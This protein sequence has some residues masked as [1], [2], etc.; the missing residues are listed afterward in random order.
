MELRRPRNKDITLVGPFDGEKNQLK[1]VYFQ[2]KNVKVRNTPFNDYY[3]RGLLDQNKSNTQSPKLKYSS[4]EIKK[5]EIKVFDTPKFLK[6][7]PKKRVI[8]NPIFGYRV[9]E[10]YYIQKVVVRPKSC[11]PKINFFQP[12][13]PEILRIPKRPKI[14][15]KMSRYNKRVLYKNTG[16]P[17]SL[18]PASLVEIQPEKYKYFLLKILFFQIQQLLAWQNLDTFGPF[19]FTQCN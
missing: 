3:K 13:K 12:E 2:K 19:Q 6:I 4:P 10:A 17:L 8:L 15:R 9:Q 14:K 11:A 16:D 1:F 5:R 7:F 18:K